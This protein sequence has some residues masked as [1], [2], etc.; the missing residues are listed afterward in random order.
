MDYLVP[1]CIHILGQLPIDVSNQNFL[2]KSD[3]FSANDS[4]NPGNPLTRS[5]ELTESKKGIATSDNKM[6][7]I[8]GTT[9]TNNN[10]GNSAHK[11]KVFDTTGTDGTAAAR[12]T[13]PTSTATTA[14]GSNRH[15]RIVAIQ[16]I[17]KQQLPPGRLP[18]Q[19]PPSLGAKP[20]DNVEPK[21]PGMESPVSE[22]QQ[23]QKQQQDA[24]VKSRTKIAPTNKRPPSKVVSSFFAHLDNMEWC[25]LQGIL[26]QFPG[27]SFPP[28]FKS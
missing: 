11:N 7:N 19:R 2:V 20:A 14:E 24:F 26:R 25:V 23:Q 10:A 21:M 12:P 9:T 22:A 15:S 8:S 5:M 4:N 27:T 6:E 18:M 17:L 3:I 16:D 1:I 13:A 28:V